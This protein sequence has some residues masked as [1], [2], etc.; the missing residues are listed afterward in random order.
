MSQDIYITDQRTNKRAMIVYGKNENILVWSDVNKYVNLST[1][2]GMTYNFDSAPTK[3]QT[4]KSPFLVMMGDDKS[5]YLF[6]SSLEQIDS[7][8]QILYAEVKR[9][10]FGKLEVSGVSRKVTVAFSD[11]GIIAAML[12][13]Q[14]GQLV[15]NLGW[16]DPK[17][18]LCLTQIQPW[19]TLQSGSFDVRL[20]EKV[21]A[22]PSM[23]AMGGRP[24]MAYF[25]ENK[26]LNIV[27]AQKNTINFDFKNKVV[28]K[29]ISSTYAPYI[30]SQ[31]DGVGYVFWRS[32]SDGSLSYHQIGM[33]ASGRVVMNAQAGGSGVVKGAFPNSAPFARMA[34]RQT[35]D[36]QVAVLQ[37]VWP[38]TDKSLISI[39]E[40]EP[41][42]AALT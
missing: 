39:A 37:A 33:S 7:G 29:E 4:A 28:F 3:Y 41:H 6:W 15:I 22:G 5:G 32:S 42:Y 38:Q 18:H 17:K 20:D 8:Y 27:M 9:N 11:D 1:S 34:S 13:T 21:N 35:D 12:A 2:P 24:T 10:T 19:K 36:R 31:S 16:K 23:I 25:D 26:H 40:F 14:N 30:V